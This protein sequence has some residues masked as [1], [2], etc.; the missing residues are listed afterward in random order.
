MLLFLRILF[1]AL[2][3]AAFIGRASADQAKGPVDEYIVLE[4][5]NF[6]N[7]LQ[8]TWPTKGK[9]AAGWL[10]EGD[11]ASE[12]EDHRGRLSQTG[13]ASLCSSSRI[14][15]LVKNQS[16]IDACEGAFFALAKGLP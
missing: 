3:T 7:T 13:I 1:A 14:S 12:A 10:A 5:E 11:K 15:P 4:A 8:K 9:D 16:I 2:M 6:L